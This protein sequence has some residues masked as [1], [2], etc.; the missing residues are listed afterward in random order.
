MS[1]KLEQALASKKV[2][3]QKLV[4]GEVIIQF[5]DS[6]IK[7]VVLSYNGIVDLLSKRGVTVDAIR[8]SNLKK[9]ILDKHV[10]I[11]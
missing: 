3:V 2:L 5:K 11:I 4:S 8:E 10:K 6:K 1:I 7:N 9:L